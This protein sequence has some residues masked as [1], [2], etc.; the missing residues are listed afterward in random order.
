MVIFTLKT[1]GIAR[2]QLVRQLVA[3]LYPSS[4]SASP[5]RNENALVLVAALPRPRGHW[6]CDEP[7]AFKN[8]YSFNGKI[9]WDKTSTAVHVTIVMLFSLPLLFMNNLE[10]GLI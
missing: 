5:L 8:K 3:I 9:S 2:F 1:E 7:V 10:T 4:I 6:V